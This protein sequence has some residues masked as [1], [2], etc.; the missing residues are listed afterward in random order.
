MLTLVIVAV[1]G[2]DAG[3]PG[4]EAV[5]VVEAVGGSR[6]VPGSL[7]AT[8]DG[9]VL[10]WTLLG[11]TGSECY[12]TRLTA[13][14]HSIARKRLEVD[15]CEDLRAAWSGSELGVVF[16]YRAP[17]RHDEAPARGGFRRFD[18]A[19]EPLGPTVEVISQPAQGGAIAWN[20][21][22]REWA[23]GWA[24]F[25]PIPGKTVLARFSAD[26]RRLDDVVLAPGRP[27][28]E[29]WTVPLVGGLAPSGDGF[30]ATLS[31]RLRLVKWTAEK[32]TQDLAALDD[33]GHHGALL[34]D[35]AQIR[36]AWLSR[37]GTVLRTAR[38]VDGKV[39]DK[40]VVRELSTDFGTG[41][42]SLH[43]AQAPRVLW[44]EHLEDGSSA[45]AF[46]ARAD[47]RVR[48]ARIDALNDGL[49][50][51][52]YPVGLCTGQGLLVVFARFDKGEQRDRLF[53]VRVP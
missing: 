2:A 41:W 42:A 8:G 3:V 5:Q 12:L 51:Q 1:L 22:T 27:L 52:R 48:P 46:V 38:V 50:D 45:R 10:A 29:G 6:A 53:L 15:S 21:A 25:L 20:G 14:G 32:G 28:G 4:V 44:H 30:V 7:V 47:G 9:F 36:A 17:P 34:T 37:R 31:P 11:A 33:D 40:V 35:G 43:C 13:A 19:L 24:G 26:G 39:K 49:G 23:V 18:A 16:R